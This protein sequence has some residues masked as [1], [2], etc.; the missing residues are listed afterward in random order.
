MARLEHVFLYQWLSFLQLTHSDQLF[1]LESAGFPEL[2]VLAGGPLFFVF[3]FE[4]HVHVGAD[5]VEDF[6]VLNFGGNLSDFSEFV[7]ELFLNKINLLLLDV[8]PKDVDEVHLV[9]SGV[10]VD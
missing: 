7:V 9:L 6:S 8:L 1:G 4:D 5:F 10:V 3:L 2:F